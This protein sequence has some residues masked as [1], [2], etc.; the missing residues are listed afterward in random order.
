MTSDP[1]QFVGDIPESYDRGLGPYIFEPYAADLAAR[2][3][4]FQPARVLE[5]ACGTGIVTRKLR[6]A[7]PETSTLTASDLNA[8]MLDVARAKFSPQER[9]AFQ[10]ADAMALPFD[11]GAFDIVA[12]Q[13]GVMFFPDKRQ[14]FREARRVLAPGGRYLF[15]VWDSRSNNPF[16]RIAHDVISGFFPGDPPQ[17]YAV[18]F[19]YHDADEIRGALG[20]A[21]LECEAIEI[22]K[23]EQPYD[24]DSFAH[25]LV[26]G[27]PVIAEIRTKTSVEPAEI[28][29]ALSRALT[30]EFPSGIMALQ[31]LVS[32]G[33]KP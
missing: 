6:D 23:F 16:A 20:D 17:F 9:I 10:T 32:V 33:R 15:N 13:F 21:G 19:S 22:V 1:T 8:P 29:G 28:V 4:D 31:A 5:I 7:L 2:V 3:A 18:P 11:D 27:N 26:H 14:A 24:A 30:S 12:C 25:G